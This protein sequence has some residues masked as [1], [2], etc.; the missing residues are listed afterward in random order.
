MK[1]TLEKI[2][3]EKNVEELKEF[4]VLNDKC[5]RDCLL[6]DYLSTVLFLFGRY[7]ETGEI[8]VEQDDDN[9]IWCYRRVIDLNVNSEE[10]CGAQEGLTRINGWRHKIFVK[11]QK[12]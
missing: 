12:Y 11:Q 8:D 3:Q 7:C 4:C 5:I 9:A 6:T 1:N 2:S 10:V